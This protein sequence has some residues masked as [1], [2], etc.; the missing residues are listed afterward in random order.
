[1][2]GC[3]KNMKDVWLDWTDYESKRN[4]EYIAAD[5]SGGKALFN[6]QKGAS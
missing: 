6:L 3:Q 4:M 1:M 5:S 2:K